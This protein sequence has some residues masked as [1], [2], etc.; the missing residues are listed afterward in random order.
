MTTQR[1]FVHRP[2]VAEHHYRSRANPERMCVI[3]LASSFDECQSKVMQI[4]DES[5]NATFTLPAKTA[6]G[7]WTAYGHYLVPKT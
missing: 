7:E 2:D 4:M 1:D 5:G 3:V 6:S